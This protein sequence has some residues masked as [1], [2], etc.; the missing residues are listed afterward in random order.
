MSHVIDEPLPGMSASRFRA[1]PTAWAVVTEPSKVNEVAARFRLRATFG[2]IRFFFKKMN[3]LF[4]LCLLAA[5]CLL[6]S[7]CAKPSETAPPAE[8]RTVDTAEHKTVETVE[9]SKSDFPKLMNQWER[10]GWLVLSTSKVVTDAD[11]ITRR[12][13]NLA[14]RKP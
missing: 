12:T 4:L 10:E 1:Q 6:A 14:K 11:G 13:V 9:R 7:G 2:P 8:H 3:A 5:G